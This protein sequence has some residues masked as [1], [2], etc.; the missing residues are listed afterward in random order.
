MTVAED[1]DRTSTPGGLIGLLRRHAQPAIAGTIVC[2]AVIAAS[3][4]KGLSVGALAVAVL[5]TSLVYWI[6]HIYTDTLAVVATRHQSLRAAT[7]QAASHTWF[8][9]AIS[10]IPLVV[11]VL[12]GLL[13]AQTQTAAYAALLATTLLLAGYG[14]MA[15][16]QGGLGTVGL[17]CAAMGGAG[18]GLLLI[19]VK[20]IV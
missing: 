17:I 15:G 13:G 7:R 9:A 3:G 16:R 19:A 5:A 1:L 20:A 14:A 10:L 2:G 8:L 4:G 12:S 6:A 11:L 18:L